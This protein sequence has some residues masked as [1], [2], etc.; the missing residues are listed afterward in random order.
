MAYQKYKSRI[1]KTQAI[2]L[3]QFALGEADRLLTLFSYDYGKIRV[4][5][6]GV[7]RPESRIG[8]HVEPLSYVSLLIARG[9][10]LDII[11]SVDTI[12]SH[13]G[14]QADLPKMARSLVCAELIDVFTADEE[15]NPALFELL[16]NTLDSIEAGEENKLL[17]YFTLHIL[18]LVGYL[19]ELQDCVVCRSKIQPNNHSFS[20]AL[21]GVICFTCVTTASDRQM[22]PVWPVSVNALKVLRYFRDSP[23]SNIRRLQIEPGLLAELERLL[24]NNVRYILDREVK[25]TAFLSRIPQLPRLI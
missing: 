3:K 24:E 20:P 8:G 22:T 6:R 13:S 5:A 10:N 23:Y 12:N 4:V 15:S 19:P 2:V 9:R 21:G 7:R 1:Y 16:L 17:W 14:L 25:S 18:R 11:S